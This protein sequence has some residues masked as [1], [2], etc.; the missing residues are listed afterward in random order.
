[1]EEKEPKVVKSKK[2][3]GQFKSLQDKYESDF[4]R[5]K[6]TNFDPKSCK[7]WINLTAKY[8]AKISQNQLLSMAEIVSTQLHLGL[9]REYKRRKEMLIKWFDENFDIV[10]PYIESHVTVVDINGNSV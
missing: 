4:V 6:L 7:A 5:E 10:W 8:G 9:F 1:M 3:K 2:T